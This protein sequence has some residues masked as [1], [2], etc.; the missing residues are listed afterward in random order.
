MPAYISIF[1]PSRARGAGASV[2]YPVRVER[3]EQSGEGV[4]VICE[5]GARVEGNDPEAVAGAIAAA[6]A[7][8]VPVAWKQWPGMAMN[9]NFDQ[10]VRV[11]G[12]GKKLVLLCRSGVRSI[13]AAK[14]AT[15]LGLEAYNILDGFEGDPD[16]QAHRGQRSGWRLHGLPWR[17]N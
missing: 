16:A 5:G 13:A 11:A 1:L 10:Q 17:Q 2:S 8:A 14:R 4:G 6:Q 9:P 7:G 15:E 3:L 12:A